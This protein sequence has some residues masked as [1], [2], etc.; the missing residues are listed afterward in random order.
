MLT[1]KGR[2][3]L[4]TVIAALLAG[5][6]AFFAVQVMGSSYDAYENRVDGAYGVCPVETWEPSGETGSTAVYNCENES[7]RMEA[8]DA[9]Q[10]AHIRSTNALSALAAL[11]F[12]VGIFVIATTI[13]HAATRGNYQKI[14]R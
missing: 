7:Q 5:G 12:F 2:R 4:F 10:T 11:T 14:D 9:A 1:Y 3:F 8:A 6:C 13:S